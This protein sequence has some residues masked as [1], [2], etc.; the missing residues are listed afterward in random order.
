[1]TCNINTFVGNEIKNF[2]EMTLDLHLESK[3]KVTV[4][5]LID[6]DLK[7][8]L[9]VPSLDLAIQNLTKQN[10]KIA[11]EYLANNNKMKVEALLGVDTI[12]YF[13]TFQFNRCM[14]GQ[15]IK[16]GNKYIPFGN[17]ES[18]LTNSQIKELK[19]NEILNEKLKTPV[20]L[21]LNPTKS[22]FSPL[23]HVLT[24]SVIEQSLENLFSLES[25]GI[26]SEGDEICDYD[27]DK[28]NFLKIKLPLK[29]VIII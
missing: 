23:E 16:V 1:M 8:D 28:L 7:L 24:D 17:I 2:K 6:N 25:I 9:E 4:P 3:T 22:Y 26:S 27:V 15:S 29:M 18:F 21:I 19:E 5:I 12:Q 10:F 20:N 11:D 13:P 14:K